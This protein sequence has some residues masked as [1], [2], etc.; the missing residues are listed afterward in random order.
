MRGA[1]GREPAR[2]SR[3]MMNLGLLLV[4]ITGAGCARAEQG[5]EESTTVDPSVAAGVDCVAALQSVLGS[6][7]DLSWEQAA[8][9]VE[10][11]IDGGDD[12][13][14]R[15]ALLELQASSGAA[16]RAAAPDDAV[17]DACESAFDVEFS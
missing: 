14:I 10:G 3:P 17:T 8:A 5:R 9:E 16:E 1:I 4:L 6:E 15:K 2:R 12:P 11:R 7:P 13:L